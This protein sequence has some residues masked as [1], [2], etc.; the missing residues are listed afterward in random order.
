MV[1]AGRHPKSAIA[2]ALDKVKQ[3]GFV[4]QEDHKKHRWG[5]VVCPAC[6]MRERVHGTPAKPDGE[7]RRLKHFAANHPTVCAAVRR[8]R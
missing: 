7:A 6:G 8:K 2:A 4:V 5:W 3:S 1:S